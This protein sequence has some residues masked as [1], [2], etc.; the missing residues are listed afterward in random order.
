MSK[1]VIIGGAVA[2]LVI[3]G[4]GVGLLSALLGENPVTAEE[5]KSDEKFTKTESG[6]KY[7]DV[8]V[9]GGTEAKN[10]SKVYVHYVGTLEDGKEFDNSRKKDKPLP[11]TIGA[12]RV[13]QGWEEGLVGMKVGGKRKLI[14]PPALAW[15]DKGAADGAIPPN[16]TVYF[17]IELLEVK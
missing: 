13:I 15:K 2:M 16:A 3:A 4:I 7:L 8:K 14:I 12:G 6:L 11:V 10:G 9:G 5:K 17:E 1:N